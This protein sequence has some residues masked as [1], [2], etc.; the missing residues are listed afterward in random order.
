MVETAGAFIK[1]SQLRF[2]SE[3][4]GVGGWRIGGIGCM[5]AEPQQLPCSGIGFSGTLNTMWDAG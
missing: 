3:C 2:F 1:L 5:L 4:L